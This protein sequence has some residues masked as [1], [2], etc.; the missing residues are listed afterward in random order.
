MADGAIFCRGVD[1]D[2]NGYK[3]LGPCKRDGQFH[4]FRR[5]DECHGTNCQSRIVAEYD[6][7]DEAGVLLYQVVR[8]QPKDF[9]QRRPDSKGG[10]IWKLQGVS[11][12]L[13][14]LPELLTAPISEPVFIVEG[15]KDVESLRRLGLVAT[16]NAMG[17]KKWRKEYNE[18]LR[19]RRVILIP[20]NDDDGREHVR[21]V[22]ESLQGIA[23]SVTVLTL[24]DLP[25]KGDVSNWLAAGG[26][27]HALLEMAASSERPSEVSCVM[28]SNDTL[29]RRPRQLP[30]YRPF[31]LHVLPVVAREYVDAA[32]AAI[33]CDHAAVGG[34]TLATLGSAVGNSRAI[35]LKKGLSEPS[36]VWVITIGDSGEKKSPAY[37]AA[38]SPLMEVQM[39]L[40]DAYHDEVAR[41]NAEVLDWKEQ[42]KDERGD[43]PE[44]PDE[45]PTYTT[46]D[47]TIESV[48]DLLSRNPRGLLL[49]R[50]ELDAWF[51]SFT[52]YRGK[53]GASDRPH[54]LELFNARTLR[55]DRITRDNKRI[56][57]R[58][59]C[60]SVTGTI[61]PAVLAR[62]LDD[63]AMAAGLG[64]RF[65]LAMPPGKRRIWT[66]AEVSEELAERYQSLLKDLLALTLAD[67]K[68]RKP[69]FLR[70]DSQAKQRW[71]EWYNSWGEQMAAS[72]GD[73]TAAMAKLEGYAARLALIHAVVTQVANGIT[74]LCPIG[75][76]SIEAGIT[77]AEWFAYEA[78]RVYCT[79]RESSEER[80]NRR[81]VD[82][83][84]TRGGRV[85][86]RDLMRGNSRRWPTRDA[87]QES[88]EA[89]VGMAL[90]TRETIAHGP[91]GGHDV[92][93][94]KLCMTHD[95]S[96]TRSD[97]END[98]SDICSD[99][100]FSSADAE[101]SGKTKSAFT[102]KAYGKP[103]R[104]EADRVSEVS[105]VMHDNREEVG[106]RVSD[107]VSEQ[108]S[109]ECRTPFDRDPGEEG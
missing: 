29:R 37:D 34:P 92:H 89:L 39:D 102:L 35:V 107:R 11:R 43:K 106:E 61:Q 44:P 78:R 96:D 47:A 6:Y 28:H 95:T 62:A 46:N 7:R 12:V 51:G 88:L 52:R 2:S 31:P 66:E 70:M 49:A 75:A 15:E 83:I 13:Y 42:S 63:E 45:P 85:T 100:R 97:S 9:R 74:E 24:P 59:A 58:R 56:A 40:L 23:S 30:P 3:H 65:L 27:K 17:A 26:T 22:A 20:D 53:A 19:G 55:L 8:F 14:R 99:T 81:L 90:A 98:S 71:I 73:Q 84:A 76:E 105:C 77:L 72:E 21:I 5:E 48:G 36:V 4:I 18:A 69:H 16:C 41:H 86:V 94:Y 104:D 57:I 10:W 50:D 67:E 54:W 103:S 79:L 108:V 68:K 87:A 25:P 32:A 82:W 80:D 64:A 38:A 60:C 109:D 33:G 101:T 1:R 91:S 93:V